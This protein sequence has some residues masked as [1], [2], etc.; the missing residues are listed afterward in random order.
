MSS[1]A[2]VQTPWALK[3]V[4]LS[5]TGVIFSSLQQAH[6]RHLFGFCGEEGHGES[7]SLGFVLAEPQIQDMFDMSGWM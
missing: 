1:M 7:C 6:K 2:C 4:L 3:I 5:W